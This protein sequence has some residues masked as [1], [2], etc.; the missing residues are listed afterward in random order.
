LGS[1]SDRKGKQ[2]KQCTVS[3][4]KMVALFEERMRGRTKC[5]EKLK[6]WGRGGDARTAKQV[7]QAAGMDE[8]GGG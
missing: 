1:Q 6:K 5:T 8:V 3:Q 7:N 2:T 4:A